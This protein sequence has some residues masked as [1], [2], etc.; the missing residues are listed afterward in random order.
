MSFFNP[1]FDELT[2]IGASFTGERVQECISSTRALLMNRF[3]AH[4][5]SRITA[6]QEYLGWS[7]AVT[8]VAFMVNK[9]G[10]K[11]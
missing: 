10:D 6:E 2:S 7:G 11:T 8:S 5:Y 9:V 4:P 3:G 1:P